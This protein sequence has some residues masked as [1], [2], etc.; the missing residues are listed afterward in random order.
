MPDVLRLG[1]EQIDAGVTPRRHFERNDAGAAGF[2]FE[3][4]PPAA[5]VIHNT[6]YAHE[7]VDQIRIER[8]AGNADIDVGAQGVAEPFADRA[9]K[10]VDHEADTHRCR[11]GDGECDYGKAGAAQGCADTLDR[12]PGRD[13]ADFVGNRGGHG[14]A[15]AYGDRN[16]QRQTQDHQK[17][18]R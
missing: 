1:V 2:G 18:R 6:G 15:G 11:D 7:I 5:A 8:T 4:D 10:T 12:E 14:H 16:A 9:S 13:A 17:Q 3:P